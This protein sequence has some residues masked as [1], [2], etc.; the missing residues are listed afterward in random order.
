[1]SSFIDPSSGRCEV[2]HINTV[3]KN[4]EKLKSI[5]YREDGI[6]T[7][8]ITEEGFPGKYFPIRVRTVYDEKFAVF[9]LK[10][11][12]LYLSSDIDEAF[13]KFGAW[14]ELGFYKLTNFLKPHNSI[15]Y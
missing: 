6:H 8:T 13:S 12:V 3:I 11:K 14:D 10:T 1:M 7:K 9:Y 4:G 15:Q 2:T 5:T